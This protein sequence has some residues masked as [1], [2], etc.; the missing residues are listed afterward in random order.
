M[1]DYVRREPGSTYADVS[2]DLGIPPCTV[3]LLGTAFREAGVMEIQQVF[4]KD[5]RREVCCLRWVGT[6]G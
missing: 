1:I 2:S 3:R 5:R 4:D 6:R